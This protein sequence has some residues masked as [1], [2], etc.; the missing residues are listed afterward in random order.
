MEYETGFG[1]V[2]IHITYIQYIQY[3]SKIHNSFSPTLY[4]TI[5]LYSKTKWKIKKTSFH[6]RL[7]IT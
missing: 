4:E 1:E 2:F 7:S 3:L 5:N 6:T